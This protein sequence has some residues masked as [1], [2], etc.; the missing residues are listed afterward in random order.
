MVRFNAILLLTLC[1][2]S[3]P[4]W[5]TQRTILV[6][7]DSLSAAYGIDAERGWVNL[8]RQRLALRDEVWNVVNRSISGDTTAGGLARLP[9]LLEQYRPSIVIIEL[10]SNDGLRGLSFKQ[11][12]SNLQAMIDAAETAGGQVLLVGGRLPPNYGAAY[13]ELFHQSFR[14]LAQVNRLP[15]VPFL[16][17][18][19]AQD[20]SLMQADGYHP[21]AQAQPLLLENVWNPLQGIL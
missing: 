9:P 16:L 15:L 7:G 1:L 12:R 14:E 20:R 8:L 3:V 10:G 19:V 17:E 18:G 4:L 5:A 13:T 21:N 6:L 11:M 2:V